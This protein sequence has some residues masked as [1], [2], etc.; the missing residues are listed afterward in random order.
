MRSPACSQRSGSVVLSSSPAARGIVIVGE[1]TV[2]RYD[3]GIFVASIIPG[4]PAE[5]D[6]RIRAVT[7]SPLP[8]PHHSNPV[9]PLSPTTS[10]LSPLSPPTITLSPLS[11]H[12]Q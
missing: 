11:P 2:G 1:D 10:T 5:K 3:L 12:H 4:G 9:L 7:L 6:G 8:S